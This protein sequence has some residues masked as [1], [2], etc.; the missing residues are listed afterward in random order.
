M[1]FQ[2][3]VVGTLRTNYPTNAAGYLAKEEETAAG[4]K[5]IIVPFLR[6]VMIR[7]ENETYWDNVRQFFVSMNTLFNIENDDL[8][9]KITVEYLTRAGD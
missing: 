3:K 9:N 4:T 5:Q 6:T 7:T 2:Q 8:A 1:D